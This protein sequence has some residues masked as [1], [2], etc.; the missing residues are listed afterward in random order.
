MPSGGSSDEPFPYPDRPC[1]P[2]LCATHG[3]DGNDDHYS[4]VNNN[5]N[6]NNNNCLSEE[7]DFPSDGGDFNETDQERRRENRN[8]NEM[9]DTESHVIN[10]GSRHE[11]DGDGEDF[12]SV[13]Q[14]ESVNVGAVIVPAEMS[15]RHRVRTS[16]SSSQGENRQNGEGVYSEEENEQ[17]HHH[18]SVLH[19]ILQNF[20]TEFH[21]LMYLQGGTYCSSSCDHHNRGQQCIDDGRSSC[22]P[23]DER[24][25]MVKEFKRIEHEGERD[26]ESE[27]KG[28]KKP[29]SHPYIVKLHDAFHG[30]NSL[31]MVM[32]YCSGGDLFE[33]LSHQ[34]LGYFEEQ[35]ARRY[36]RHILSAVTWLHQKGIAHRDISLENILLSPTTGEGRGALE[37][38]TR[39]I[40][41]MEGDYEEEEEEVGNEDKTSAALKTD[42][43]HERRSKE[44]EYVKY[45]AKLADFGLS[46]MGHDGHCS[47]HTGVGKPYYAAPEMTCAASPSTTYDGQ[48]ADRW[49]LGVLLFMMLLG[50]PPF[51]IACAYRDQT[52]GYQAIADGRIREVITCWCAARGRE[53]PLSKPAV[54]LLESMLHVNP[55]HRPSLQ[56]IASHPWVRGMEEEAGEK[57]S[58]FSDH[59][60]RKGTYDM[61]QGEERE[62]VRQEG[63]YAYSMEE[64][65]ILNLASGPSSAGHDTVSSFSSLSISVASL[66]ALLSPPTSP[67]GGPHRLPMRIRVPCVSSTT[68]FSNSSSSSCTATCTG[69][70]SDGPCYR[71]GVSKRL[72]F[73]SK[74]DQKSGVM[75]PADSE[76]CSACA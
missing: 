51:E 20:V 69:S 75:S 48:E 54:E 53:R 18:D 34:P 62:R 39:H 73:A 36:F 65:P 42:E 22:I 55:S 4:N 3:S 17:C 70:Q 25:G 63:M 74:N 72:P 15:S 32:E 44:K 40:M 64:N 43:M 27:M 67:T 33:E 12:Q 6:N 35:E 10:S 71:L 30:T 14:C 47:F 56:D 49:S 68:S 23:G 50:F 29:E 7:S 31:F 5:N 8:R 1:S 58:N 21:V 66:P 45:V 11:I 59:A 9:M 57:R 61:A 13:R 46:G 26:K 28:R 16:T 2:F 37:G 52:G 38:P 76:T 19:E 24:R 60:V 41:C